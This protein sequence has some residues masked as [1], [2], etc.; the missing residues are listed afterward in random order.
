MAISTP[1]IN[2]VLTKF[3]KQINFEYVRQNLFSPYMGEDMGAIIRIRRELTD[4][5]NQM[6]IP[7]VAALTGAGVGSGP[8]V[9]NEEKIDDYG[10]RLWI[11][12]ARNAVVSNKSAR[13]KDSAE[14]FDEARSLLGDWGK[15]KQRDEIVDALYA[16]PSESAPVLLDS[17]AGQRVNGIQFA[18]ATA[19]QRNTWLTDNSD[20]VL[21]GKLVSNGVSNVFATATATLDTTD[22]RCNR[23]A[24]RLL[25][26]IAK[27]ATPKLRP[28]KTTDG[29]EYFVAFHG[30]RTFRDLKQDL[31]TI[32]ATARPREGNGMDKNP[33]F[34][35]GDLL[36]DGVIHREVP[37]IDT[38]CPAYY[39]LAGA[40]DASPDTKTDVRP[41]WMCGQGAL[42]FGWGQMARPTQ[43]DETDYQFL[44]GVGVEMA[45]G[46]GKM[47]KKTIA[48]AL[49]EW[50][51]ATGFF[52]AAPDS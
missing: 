16:L 33:I 52:A 44:K 48:G 39:D 30:T 12:Y 42:A 9:G 47:F 28:Y 2:N 40:T 15:S 32:N 8:L 1:Q 35:D 50:S 38:R 22:D 46:V 27:N 5:G 6:N 13:R 21:F 25:K 7:L 29:R 45:Y 11:D 10:M 4:A 43:R 14:V 31:E 19:A 51:I 17:N 34:Q 41:V 20:R 3:T 37:E 23:A 26:R 24:M 36:D 49:K 18:A